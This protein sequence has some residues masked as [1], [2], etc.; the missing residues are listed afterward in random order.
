[1]KQPQDRQGARA[2]DPP[3][4]AAA[5]R[6]G[7]RV[8][9]R[10]SIRSPRDQR[11]GPKQLPLVA[12]PELRAGVEPGPCRIPAQMRAF[13]RFR[14]VV[15]SVPLLVSA[16]LVIAPWAQDYV[17]V[18]GTVQWLAGQTLT[19]VLDGPTGPRTYTIIGQYLVP[20][21]GPR[22]TV[23]IDLSQLPQSEYAFIRSGERVSVIGVVS[24]DRRRLIGTSIIRGAGQQA[25]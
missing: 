4:A 1:M 20:V 17:R 2:H 9:R 18:D 23:N 25:P 12:S 13:L 3:I 22:Q 14:F 11:E 7:D 15:G 21:P 6:S 19:L 5:G 10:R 8:S 16:L 24:D